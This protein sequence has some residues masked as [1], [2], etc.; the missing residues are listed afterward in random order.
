MAKIRD[1]YNIQQLKQLMTEMDSNTQQVPTLG[2]VFA[3][4]T[5]FDIDRE[6]K[7]MVASRW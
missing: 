6:D 7:P 3:F 1:V 5:S 2:I 4:V